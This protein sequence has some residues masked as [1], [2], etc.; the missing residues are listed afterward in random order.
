LV[1]LQE[2]LLLLHP[3]LFIKIIL[4]ILML[5]GNAG[6]V[7][8]AQLKRKRPF[9]IAFAFIFAS[10][11]PPTDAFSLILLVIPLLILYELTILLIEA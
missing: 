3:F 11:L 8:K 9:F 2:G 4:I 10:L 6:L 5:M 7:D 1:L